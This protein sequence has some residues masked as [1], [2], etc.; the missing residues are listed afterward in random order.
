M[1]KFI[2]CS[3]RGLQLSFRLQIRKFILWMVAM[4]M[5]CAL[6]IWLLKAWLPRHIWPQAPLCDFGVTK[7]SASSSH[8]MI[9]F[10]DQQV[11]EELG[12][13]AQQLIK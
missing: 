12:Q 13:A 8:L 10:L 7:F 1:G 2:E 3:G 9:S 6:M 11:V 4:T 5:I